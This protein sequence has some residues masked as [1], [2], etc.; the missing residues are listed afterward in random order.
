MYLF[1]GVPQGSVLWLLLL[2]LFVYNL[3]LLADN[4]DFMKYVGNNISSENID[5]TLE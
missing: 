5:I 3:F 1:E 4:A 2:N